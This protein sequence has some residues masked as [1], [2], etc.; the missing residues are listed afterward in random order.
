MFDRGLIMSEVLF[1][2]ATHVEI[3]GDRALR[4]I[5]FDADTW[6]DT[7]AKFEVIG[8]DNPKIIVTD[9]RPATISALKSALKTQKFDAI[10]KV[11]NL[12]AEAK[13]QLQD[14]G[15]ILVDLSPTSV[16]DPS[17]RLWIPIGIGDSIPVYA[18]LV[19]R[20]APLDN[21]SYAFFSLYHRPGSVPQWT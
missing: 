14:S 17:Y 16:D 9:Y 5:S 2:G 13:V 20:I 10:A 15:R 1:S 19:K 8:F 18:Y 21:T 3:Q 12:P 4:L 6:K 11:L 7:G